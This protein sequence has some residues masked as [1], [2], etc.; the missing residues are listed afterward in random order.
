MLLVFF[1][2][3]VV[4]VILIVIIMVV[5][6]F[7]IM[8]IVHFKHGIFRDLVVLKILFLKAVS[9]VQAAHITPKS[10]VHGLTVVNRLRLGTQQST[11]ALQIGHRNRVVHNIHDAT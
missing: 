4:M 6:M 10:E 3:I 2:V 5:V 1:I 8:V 7:V 11:E 9:Q